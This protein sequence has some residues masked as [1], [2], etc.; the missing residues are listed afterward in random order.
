MS[1]E[2]DICRLLIT[3][4]NSL[5]ADQARRCVGPDMGPNCLTSLRY[6]RMNFLKRISTKNKDDKNHEKLPS[7]Q[8]VKI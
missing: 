5:N 4:A 6:S 2:D 3:V 8:I 1:A 7:M